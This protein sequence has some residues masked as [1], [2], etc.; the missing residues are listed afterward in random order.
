MKDV[1][2]G[3]Q[4]LVTHRFAAGFTLREQSCAYQNNRFLLATFVDHGIDPALGNLFVRGINPVRTLRATNTSNNGDQTKYL[5][6]N[7]QVKF[8]MRAWLRV[9]ARGGG[10]PPP[11]QGVCSAAASLR[12]RTAAAASYPSV[13]LMG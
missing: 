7:C 2:C 1:R 4:N 11:A 6:F 8:K 3:L 12:A 5:S 13:A 10:M 9:L